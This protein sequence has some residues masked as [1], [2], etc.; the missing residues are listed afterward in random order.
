MNNKRIFEKIITEKRAKSSNERP[1]YG[2]R[3]LTVGVVSCLLGYMMFFTPNVV[4][5]EKVDQS[6]AVEATVESTEVANPENVEEESEQPKEKPAEIAGT[7]EPVSHIEAYSS[8][9]KETNAQDRTVRTTDE[10]TS[11]TATEG[12][13]EQ[14]KQADSYVPELEAIKVVKGQSVEDY[15]KAF[16]NLPEDAT[17]KVIN[18]ADTN[19]AG[20]KI[21]TVE[22]TFAD[23]SRKQEIIT[24]RVYKTQEDLDKE[25]LDKTGLEISTTGAENSKQQAGQPASEEFVEE[26]AKENWD[27]T[28]EDKSR[29]AVGKDQR[30][31][32]VTTSDP[33]EMNDV[34]YDGTFV[35]ANGRTVIRLLYKEKA[36][37]T[38]GVWYRALF[39]FGELDQFID[40]DSSYV[41]GVTIDGKEK[42][43]RA[44]LTPFN[45]GKERMFDLGVSRGDGTN[46]RKNLPIN[47]VL[48]DG[49]TLKDL[50]EK[51]YTVQMRLTDAKGKRIYAY[52]PGKSSMDYSTY[53]KTTSIS[54]E[55]KVNSLFL[56]GGYQKDSENA[57]KQESFMSEFIANP[58]QYDDKSNLGIIRTQYTGERS[59]D[60]K[61]PTV[62]GQQIAFTQAFDANL[63]NYLK[64]DKDGNVAYVN[65][66]ENT[67]L[68]SKYSHSIGIKLKDFNKTA[69]G[70]LA[71]LVI[72]THDFQKEGVN[73]VEVEKHDQYTMIQGYYITGIDYVVDKSK[74]EDTFDQSKTRKLDYSMI[75]GW[76]NPNKD[77]WAVFEKS[78]DNGFVAQEG[79]SYLVDTT[80]VPMTKKQK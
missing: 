24:V 71:Y 1:K 14:A 2:L 12:K 38:S 48:K 17:I 58:E 49:V 36:A 56:K 73:K 54:L 21:A 22:I 72:G 63:L 50:A 62:G 15:R 29:W 61:A 78:Y 9:A 57:T 11:E 19:E 25:E 47:L 41:V 5:A 35:D 27:K 37:A 28:P 32:R 8:N 44:N 53:T 70:K 39:N 10:K 51:N 18:E 33:V 40:Y 16:K 4:T 26:K 59:G 45:D 79:D 55:D 76:V 80:S 20:E 67:R 74:F 3:K 23:Q 64:A 46:Q 68:K 77:G 7:E 31:V 30:L 6:Q 66:F 60:Y 65:V 75:S 42:S 52:A 69:D 34:D 43:D 13:T